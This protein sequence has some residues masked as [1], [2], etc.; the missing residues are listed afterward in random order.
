MCKV[1]VNVKMTEKEVEMIFESL[2]FL[3]SKIKKV[4]DYKE[5]AD[6]FLKISLMIKEKKEEEG[7]MVNDKK[8]EPNP[9]KEYINK[10]TG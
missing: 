5:L 3:T 7:K 8:E 4:E 9:K 10:I 2:D 1:I 6:D